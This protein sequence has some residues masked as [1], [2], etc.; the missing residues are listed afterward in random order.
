MREIDPELQARLDGG[1]TRLCRAWVVGRRDGIALGFTD[2]DHDLVVDGTVCRA[3]SGM[4]ASAL[5]TGTGL[6]VDNAGA[7]GALSGVAIT[8]EDIRAGRYDGAEVRHWLVDWE[9]PDLRVLLFKGMFGEIRRADGAFEV[10]LRGLAEPLNAPVG[11]TVL[12]TCDRVLGDAKCGFDTGAPGFTVEGTVISAEGVGLSVAG[13]GGFE[14]GW[15][16][17]GR[18]TWLSGRNLGTPASVKIDRTGADGLRRL[19]LWQEPAFP[20]AAADR[21]EVVAG[22]DKTAATCRAKFANFLN[23]RG[24]P[25]IPGTD[26]VTAYPKDGAIND[27]ASLQG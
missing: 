25:H 19:T 8:E 22:C 23:F 3:S 21:F 13:L 24:F 12:K 11:R 10:E 5:Q 20:A 15:F 1:A 26:W 27:G 9:R 7:G 2:H 17:H 6:S 4:K 16:T 18:L 14:A